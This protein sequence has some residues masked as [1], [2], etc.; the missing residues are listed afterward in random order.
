MWG[1]WQRRPHRL[2]R[3]RKTAALWSAATSGR[4]PSG[5]TDEFAPSSRSPSAWQHL[6]Q[7]V[8]I[9]R[10]RFERADAV[11]M[12]KTDDRLVERRL[13][14]HTPAPIDDVAVEVVDLGAPAAQHILKHGGTSSGKPL[15]AGG[16]IGQQLVRPTAGGTIN[17]ALGVNAVDWLD[18]EPTPPPDAD[19]LRGDLDRNACRAWYAA[20][21]RRAEAAEAGDRVCHAV[22]RELRPALAE[23]VGRHL[24]AGHVVHHLGQPPSAFGVL[25]VELAD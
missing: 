6:H 18:L 13:H 15:G 1:L 24:G 20:D 2:Q 3:R 23:K 12:D 22:H 14:L 9:V 10:G 21:L 25:A 4:V 5:V 7:R 16:H 11:L 17:E 8:E 19:R